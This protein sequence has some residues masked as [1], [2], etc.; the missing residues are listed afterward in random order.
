MR[1]H[2]VATTTAQPLGPPLFFPTGVGFRVAIFEACSE[3]THGTACMLAKS[4][5]AIL[6]TRD[7][8]EFVD[9][10]DAPIASG[11]SDRCPAAFSPAGDVRLFTGH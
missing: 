7:Y 1:I 6:Y 11:W 5:S 3:F 10:P 2:T 8:A 4:P 9:S